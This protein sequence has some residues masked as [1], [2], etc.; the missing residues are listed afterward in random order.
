MQHRLVSA[1]SIFLILALLLMPVA[2]VS[3]DTGDDINAFSFYYDHLN[4]RQQYLYHW[5]KSF[6]DN[7]EYLN[8]D[9]D[10]GLYKIDVAHLFP[11]NPTEEDCDAF[12][13]DLIYAQL[14]LQADE[15]QYLMVGVFEGF[16]CDVQAGNL[17]LSATS[18]GM[19]SIQ[20]T[21]KLVSPRA[22]GRLWI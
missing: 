20:K 9:D 8:Y 11:D 3:A 21:I 13:A 18:N 14:A 22:S 19:R 16:G 15:P 17:I 4:E 6:I 7:K 1:L 5:V 10:A 12:F 2:S